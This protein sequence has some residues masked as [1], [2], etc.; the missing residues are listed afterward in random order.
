MI[1]RTKQKKK[2]ITGQNHQG[3]SGLA[4]TVSAVAQAGV[5]S[6]WI[7]TNIALAATDLNGNLSIAILAQEVPA[8]L[9]MPA[10]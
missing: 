5:D 10:E 6:A 2:S 9:C 3:C 4:A 1:P 7:A 8:Q